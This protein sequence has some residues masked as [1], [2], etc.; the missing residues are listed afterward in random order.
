MFK[1]E[2]G[3]K[4]SVYDNAVGA[5]GATVTASAVIAK[6]GQATASPA[7]PAAAPKPAPAEAGSPAA[8]ATQLPAAVQ[9]LA[10]TLA[11]QAAIIVA[12]APAAAAV[13]SSCAAAATPLPPGLRLNVNLQQMKPIRTY[14]QSTSNIGHATVELQQL[15]GQG[16]GGDVY[17]A[18][19]CSYQLTAQ[20]AAVPCGSAEQPQTVAVKFPRRPDIQL[21]E[22]G[23]RMFLHRT[24]RTLWQEHDLLA[25]M[26]DCAWI[27]DSYGYGLAAAADATTLQGYSEPYPCLLLEWAEQGSLWQQLVPRDGASKRMSAADTWLVVHHMW[28]ALRHCHQ[29]G[30]LYRDLKPHNVLITQQPGGLKQRR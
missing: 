11:A 28:M 23:A 14:V 1:R 29:Q 16:G 5:P 30:Y 20:G 12:P 17:K 2:I 22:H 13:A 8:P 21:T 24:K 9:L 19:L 18:R 27:I 3:R 10:Q 15:V 6:P 4:I 25:L 7:A 26:Q